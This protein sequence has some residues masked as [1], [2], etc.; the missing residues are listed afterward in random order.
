MEET[1]MKTKRSLWFL[2]A[3]VIALAPLGATQAAEPEQFF[4]MLA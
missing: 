2:L 3:L 1:L 4:P